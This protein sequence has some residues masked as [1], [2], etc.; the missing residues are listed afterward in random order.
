MIVVNGVFKQIS[1][2]LNESDLI[3]GFSRTF[4]IGKSADKTG[5]FQHSKEFKILNDI[6]LFYRPSAV[7]V[8]NAFR[9]QSKEG[10]SS[11][12]SDSIEIVTNEDK[13][14]LITILNDLTGLSSVWCRKWVKFISGRGFLR[15]FCYSI[16]F[17]LSPTEFSNE[18][19]GIFVRHWNHSWNC[20]RI[21]KFQ[22]TRSNAEK[23]KK[24]K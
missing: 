14:G 18:P 7:Q 22:Q 5:M 9:F 2:F 24:I 1:K 21:I 6:S 16:F 13:L 15:D 20:W 19:N 23:R 8:E 12:T 11:E 4:I 10:E 3:L 17:F